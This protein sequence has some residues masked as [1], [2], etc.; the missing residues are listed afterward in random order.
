M[1]TDTTADP[2]GQAGS[3]DSGSV[4]YGL[5]LGGGGAVGVAWETAVLAALD[6]AGVHLTGAGIVVGTSAGSI[7]GAQLLG[8][9]DFADML[10]EQAVTTQPPEMAER[11]ASEDPDDTLG[12]F[13]EVAGLTDP[14]E[15]GRHLGTVGLSVPTMP[16][17]AYLA[18]MAGII[19]VSQWPTATRFVPT[20]VDCQTGQRVGWQAAPDI[21]LVAAVASSCCVPGMVPPVTIRGRRYIDGGMWSPSNADLLIGSEVSRALFIGPFGG[22]GSDDVMNARAPLQHELAALGNPA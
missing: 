3:Q 5:V 12:I 17:Q 15:R 10:A 1:M 14:A 4:R 8:R 20:A 22:P 16:E 21:P 7:V 19:Q 6:E 2:I 9:R 11:A 18:M 13:S